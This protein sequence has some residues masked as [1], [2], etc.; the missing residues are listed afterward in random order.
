MRDEGEE[1]D[2]KIS[3]VEKFRMRVC[4]SNGGWGGSE[5]RVG[6]K[7]RRQVGVYV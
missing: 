1:D 2:G 5:G 6:M 4:S 3:W 7:E